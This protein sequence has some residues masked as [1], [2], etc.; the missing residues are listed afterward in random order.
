[1]VINSERKYLSFF[2]CPKDAPLPLPR[3]FFERN[4]YVER[5]NYYTNLRQLVKR[6]LMPPGEYVLVPSTFDAD[7]EAD[8]LLRVFFENDN[9]AE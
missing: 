7:V 5:C 6:F 9:S 1:M 2:Q 4:H 3:S 8:F